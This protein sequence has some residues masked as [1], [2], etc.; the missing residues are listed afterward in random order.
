MT[1]LDFGP[2]SN[3][4]KKKKTLLILIEKHFFQ[5]LKNL[6]PQLYSAADY[7]EKSYLNSDK[8]PM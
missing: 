3:A 5:E 6:R 8:K 7:C 1:L 4:K 2:L